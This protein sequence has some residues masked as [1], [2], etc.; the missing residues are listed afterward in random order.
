AA[1]VL[2]RHR[3]KTQAALGT[4]LLNP[5]LPK[6]WGGGWDAD[7]G[8]NWQTRDHLRRLGSVR[9]VGRVAVQGS[10]GSVATRS[11]AVTPAPTCRRESFPCVGLPRTGADSSTAA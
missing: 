6:S 2:A 1:C 3:A 7:T 8:A 5:T 11:P 9:T 10:F 4:G